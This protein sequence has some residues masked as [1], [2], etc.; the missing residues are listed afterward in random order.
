MFRSNNNFAYLNMNN[1]GYI[2]SDLD[3]CKLG[4]VDMLVNQNAYQS[5]T[6][7][8]VIFVTDF[9][10][11]SFK[12]YSTLIK[13]VK[14]KKCIVNFLYVGSDHNKGLFSA[15]FKLALKQF[16][17]I[18]PVPSIGIV[19]KAAERNINKGVSE[20]VDLFG[21]DLVLLACKHKQDLS[22]GSAHLR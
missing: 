17:K 19:W 7:N 8:K 5:K 13:I 4:N 11:N 1:L 16:T 10:D 20:V 18:C 6:I 21:G 3:N 15:S 22:F 9:S 14:Q 12:I 2:W